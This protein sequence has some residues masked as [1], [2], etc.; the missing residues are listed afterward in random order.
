EGGRDDPGHHPRQPPQSQGQ[1]I[2]RAVQSAIHWSRLAA[3]SSAGTSMGSEDS[4]ANEAQSA[5]SSTSS[6]TG[7]MYMFSGIEACTSGES[8][9]SMNSRAPCSFSA[10]S[11]TPAYSTCR[12]QVS[13]RASVVEALPS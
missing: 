7:Y 8:R 4:G 9:K 13:S 11:I 1:P 6:S 10:P 5:G 2:T 3:I 12:K